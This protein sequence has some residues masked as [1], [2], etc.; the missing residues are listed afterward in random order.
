MSEPQ[1]ASELM[2]QHQMAA[3]Q[4]PKFVLP[5]HEVQ[6]FLFDVLNKT[7]FPGSMAEFVVSVKG[8]IA[9]ATIAGGLHG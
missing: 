5:S 3:A 7:S 4:P 2:L 9:N 8:Q 1:T 6:Q